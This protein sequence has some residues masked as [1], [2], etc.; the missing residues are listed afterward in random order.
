MRILL[1]FF[2][3]VFFVYLSFTLSYW[4]LILALWFAFNTF[5][6]YEIRR[7]RRMR[8]KINIFTEQGKLVVKGINKKIDMWN[9]DFSKRNR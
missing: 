2:A 6:L 3:F 4:Y 8:D 7:L 5:R 1:N 9:G